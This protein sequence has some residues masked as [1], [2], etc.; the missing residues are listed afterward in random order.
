M[1]CFTQSHSKSRS[2]FSWRVLRVSTFRWTARDYALAEIRLLPDGLD[3]ILHDHQFSFVA[4]GFAESF[5]DASTELLNERWDGS[6]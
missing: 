3:V 1:I 4:S 5:V 2:I 6:R